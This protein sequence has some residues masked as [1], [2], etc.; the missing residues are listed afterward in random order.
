[1]NIQAQ[2]RVE[3]EIL[4]DGMISIS[5]NSVS[6][7]NHVEAQELVD[8][9]LEEVGGP[10]NTVHKPHSHQHGHVHTHTQGQVRA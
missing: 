1:M 10:R 2:D 4:A 8:S 6:E 9:T 7:A 3:C 5:T